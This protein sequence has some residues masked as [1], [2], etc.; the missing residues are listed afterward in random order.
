MIRIAG[1]GRPFFYL[2]VRCRI[3]EVVI[4]HG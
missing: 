2:L 3:T 4:D 1:K